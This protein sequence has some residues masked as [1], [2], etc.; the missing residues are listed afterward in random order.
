MGKQGRVLHPEENRL[1][2]VRECAR[3]Q[4]HLLFLKPNLEAN[5]EGNKL[6]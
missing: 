3:S 4:A 5:S 2:S 6:S 1:I